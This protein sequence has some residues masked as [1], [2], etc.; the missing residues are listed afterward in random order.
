MIEIGIA[1]PMGAG[2]TTLANTLVASHQFR[3]MSLA[4][5]LRYLTTLLLGRAIDKKVDRGVLQRVGGAARSAEW[6][7]IDTPLESARQE[8]VAALAAHIFPGAAPEQV[9][10]L[11]RAL[12]REGYSYGWGAENYWLGRWQRDHARGP[13]PVVVDDLRFPIEGNFLARKGFFLVMLDVPLEERKRRIIS[14]DGLWDPAWSHDPTEAVADQIPAHV[15]L[16][17]TASPE[18]LAQQVLDAAHAWDSSGRPNCPTVAH[19]G[20]SKL[21]A[22]V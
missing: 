3:R 21:L 9:A 12:Y 20:F 4:D 1:G 10:A 14:R 6:K 17:G 19:Q 13:R 18:T 11:Y 8:R 16:E 5:P 2:K 22:P 15:C 7:D